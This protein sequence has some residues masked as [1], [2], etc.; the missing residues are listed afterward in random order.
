MAEMEAARG[1]AA[2]R[3]YDA[4][5]RRLRA[6]HLRIHPACVHCGIIRED[7]NVDHIV[8]HRG[9]DALR[10]DPRNLQTLCRSHSSRKTASRDGGFGN[11]R[12]TTG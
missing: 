5:W 3:G 1:G 2:A 11:P 7:N 10:L 8:P 4:T 9:D 12:R 6:Q